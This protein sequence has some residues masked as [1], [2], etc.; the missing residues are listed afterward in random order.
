MFTYFPD[1]FLGT[2]LCSS[3]AD[4]N[5]L[6]TVLTNRLDITLHRVINDFLMYLVTHRNKT[7]QINKQEVLGR[8]N[9]L[10]SFDTTRTA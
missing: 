7:F 10:L 3:I 6:L 4:T 5:Q 8:T 2:V 1:V 9:R